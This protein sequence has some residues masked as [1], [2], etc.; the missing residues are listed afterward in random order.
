MLLIYCSFLFM[1]TP[2]RDRVA[3]AI[4]ATATLTS[5][6]RVVC[7]SESL[8]VSVIVG[9]VGGFRRVALC[10]AR[11]SAMPPIFYFLPLEP[12][13]DPV[14][15]SSSTIRDGL[16]ILTVLLNGN[17]SPALQGSHADLVNGL[18]EG[19]AAR[20]AVCAT[21][22]SVRKILVGGAHGA[23]SVTC[24]PVASAVSSRVSSSA[25]STETSLPFQ[26]LVGRGAVHC[27]PR[28]SPTLRRVSTF[29]LNNA[30]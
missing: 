10:A 18:K 6:V 9:G 27:R 13:R 2:A 12:K 15:R 17:L 16:S 3:M 25:E 8:L 7:F 30:P 1:W 19:G 23:L 14:W 22:A 26:N 20:A 4:G 21:S 29:W 11:V 5:I 24:W 28:I